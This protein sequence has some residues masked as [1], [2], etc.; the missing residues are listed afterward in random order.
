MLSLPLNHVIIIDEM[1]L[2]AQTREGAL[3]WI[4]NNE[5]QAPHDLALQGLLEDTG[6]WF[7]DRIE[8]KEW[9]SASASSMLWLHGIREYSPHYTQTRTPPLQ[10]NL[11]ADDH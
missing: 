1:L 2:A 5:Y 10:E 7:F 3:N 9:R 4:T 11:A 8:Y 6:K